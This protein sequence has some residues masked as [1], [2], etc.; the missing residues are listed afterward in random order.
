MAIVFHPGKPRMEA[1]R[2]AVAKAEAAAGWDATT[3][4]ETSADDWGVSAAQAAL[5]DGA[6]VV[7]ASGGDGTVRA[8]AEV[9]RGSD[10]PMA[11]LPRGTGNLLA[12]NLRIPHSSLDGAARIA[13]GESTRRM[14]VGVADL[15]RPESATIE[16]HVFLVMAGLGV[17]A[18]MVRKTDPTLKKAVGWLAYA[19][20]IARA[21]PSSE[22]FRITF[23]L[24]GE[25]RRS[26]MV[27]TVMAANCGVLPTGVR[28]MPGA[29]VDD[30][31]L[32]VAAVRARGPLGW[33][34]VWN[35]VVIENGVL[36]RSRVGRRIAEWRS[37]SV[38]DVIYRQTTGVSFA[39]A[40]PAAC[41]LDGD[42][43]GE[44]AAARAWVDP[45]SLLVKAPTHAG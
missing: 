41:Q 39:L 26:A 15:M 20:A 16:R 27:H 45:G 40:M 5:D 37:E 9:M 43:F 38:R 12:R 32:D 22:A 4:Y 3:W 1:L 6:T 34:R 8:V 30:G 33:F 31:L 21:L 13:F 24:D 7:A 11:L 2:R 19:D 10:V 29:R 36:R 14:D 18:E 25:P 35:T 42:D 28:L 44:V 17:D 23:A